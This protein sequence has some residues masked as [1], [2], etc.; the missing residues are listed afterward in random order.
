MSLDE[1]RQRG[2]QEESLR[3]NP[4]LQKIFSELKES[5]IRDWSQTDRKDTEKREHAFYL[6]KAV[7]EI[8]LEIAS[9][10]SS[11]QMATQQIDSIVRKK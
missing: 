8:E 1:E 4:L 2:L 10:I 9:L 11:G 6:H 3:N 5:Y 7:E